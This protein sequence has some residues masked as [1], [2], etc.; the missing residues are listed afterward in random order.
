MDGIKIRENDPEW[1]RFKDLLGR[2][3]K[4]DEKEEKKKVQSLGKKSKLKEMDNQEPA[5]TE[6]KE[7]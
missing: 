2:K 3:K 7:M 5:M 4:R 1:Q 6:S